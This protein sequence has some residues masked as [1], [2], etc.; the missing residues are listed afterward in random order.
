MEKISFNRDWR[1]QQV[2]PRF[3]PWTP[4]DTSGWRV[5]DLPHDWS[6]ELERKPENPSSNLGGYFQMGS[7]WYQKSFHAHQAWSENRILVEFEGVYMNAEVFINDHPLGLHPYGYTTFVH[8]LTPHLKWGE[9]NDLRVFVDNSHPLNARWYSG[10]GIYRPVWL[11]VLNPVHISHWGVFISTPDIQPEVATVKVITRIENNTPEKCAV[12]LRSRAVS[13]EG[14]IVAVSDSSC[15]VMA[16]KTLEINDELLVLDP[17]LWSPDSP[18]LYHLE[19]EI[20]LEDTIVDHQT[21]K[22]GIRKLEFS[23][24]SGFRINGVPLKFQGGCVHHDNGILGAASYPRSEERKVAVHKANGFNAIRCAHNPPSPAFLDA[25]DRLGMLVIDEAFDVWRQGKNPGDYHLHFDDWWQRDLDSMVLRDRNHPSVILWSIGNELVERAK[26][27]GVRI[28]ERLAARIRELD[29]TRPITA[30]VNDG[31]EFW[32][33][34]QADGFFE[35]LDVCGYNYKW[36]Q[37][38]PD[39]ERHPQ[40]MIIGTESTAGEAFD[41]WTLVRQHLHILGDFVW[42]SLDYLG[43]SGIGR[44]YYEGEPAD[45][46]PGYPW[47]QAY[48]GDLDL[49]GYKRPQSY[50][51]DI[52][53]G[54]GEKLYIAVHAPLPEGKATTMSYWGWPDVWSDWN[55][56]GHEDQILKVYVYSACDAVE[57]F[58]NGRPLGR[59]PTTELERHIAAFD[60]P[61]Q[62]GV[63]KAIG[64]SDGQV[65]AE[66]ELLTVGEPTRIRLTAEQTAILAGESDLCFVIVEILDEHNHLHPSSE[67]EIFFTTQGAGSIAAVGNGNPLSMENYTGNSRRAFRGRCMVVLKSNGEP[68]R[69]VLRAQADGL[70]GD[71]VVIHV[72]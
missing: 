62:P 29:P 21:T 51:R 45:F 22:F 55:W 50:Y 54:R 37:Y 6:I 68:G 43:E 67:Q 26:P 2:E 30:A 39:H 27:E 18:H 7:G 20:L 49:C 35:K 12:I 38:L 3:L 63:L 46:L 59:Q 60:V 4:E 15:E 16:G 44:E 23:S 72:S 56:R 69:I 31:G 25:C 70:H 53:W 24:E 17:L 47:H 57:L 66:K 11:W 1:F 8:D 40:R 28:A 10:S 33:W 13:P 52:L 41:H 61:Y 71:E 64:F 9:A 19:S 14:V 65:A 36:R 48:C 32:Q 34:E 58:L 42:T 5:L